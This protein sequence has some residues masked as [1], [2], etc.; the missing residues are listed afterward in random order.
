MDFLNN[1]AKQV[2][3]AA[4]GT[5]SGAHHSGSG[6][7]GGN[8]PQYDQDR[9]KQ[10]ASTLTNF[11]DGGASE[12]QRKQRLEE[13][14]LADEQIE[15]KRHQR[16]QEGFLGNIK[17]MWDGGADAEQQRIAA[18]RE[19]RRKEEEE[20]GVFGQ[21]QGLMGL[22]QEQEQSTGSGG[23]QGKIM[24]VFGGGQQQKKP[25]MVDHGG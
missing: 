2:Q 17:D 12:Y 22:R 15:R 10:Y 23:V 3:S 1:V 11:L 19:R 16:D 7:T 6:G 4:G 18:E 5:S 8:E 13:Q 20:A 14:R 9:T 25:D 21:V 24:G